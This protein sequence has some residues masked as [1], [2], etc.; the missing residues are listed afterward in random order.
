M[1]RKAIGILENIPIAVWA[2]LLVSVVLAGGDLYVRY[3]ARSDSEEFQRQLRHQIEVQMREHI[4]DWE[5]Q[6][7]NENARNADPAR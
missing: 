7:R 2:V 6:Q 5:R 4:R 1:L 3:K